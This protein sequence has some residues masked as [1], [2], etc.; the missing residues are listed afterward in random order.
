MRRLAFGGDEDPHR[1]KEF[2]VYLHNT[3]IIISSSLILFL[4]LCAQAQRQAV[5]CKAHT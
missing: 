3:I 2:D 1:Y 4:F 5:Q